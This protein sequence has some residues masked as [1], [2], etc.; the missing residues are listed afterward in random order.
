MP[1]SPN[2]SKRVCTVYTVLLGVFIGLVGRLAWIQLYDHPW[3]MEQARQRQF[4]KADILARR[5]VIFDRCKRVLAESVWVES[6]TADPTII[7]DKAG[8][9]RLLSQALRLDFRQTLTKLGRPKRFVWIKRFLS[10]REAAIVRQANLKGIFLVREAKRVYPLG[11]VACHLVGFCSIDGDGLEG[12]EAKCDAV[13]SGVDGHRD[14]WRDGAQRRL[15]LPSMSVAR[16]R[17]GRSVVLTVDS[18]IQAIVHQELA[19]AFAKL[20]PEAA[21]GIVLDCNTGGVLSM[22]SLPD[23]YPDRFASGPGIEPRRFT[24]DYAH[25]R[26]NRALTDLF[27]PGSIFK[28]FVASGAFELG[29][30][31][32]DDVFDCHQGSYAFGRRVL[33]DAHGYGLLTAREVLIKSSNIGLAQIAQKAGKECVYAYLRKFGFGQTTGFDL[34]GEPCGVLRQPQY[35]KP[36]YSLPS[37]GMGQEVSATPLRLA[38]SFCAL[39]N[40]GVVPRPYVIAAHENPRTGEV[41]WRAQPGQGTVRAIEPGTSRGIMAPILADVVKVGTGRYAAQEGYTLAGKTGTAQLRASNGRGYAAKAFFSSF[42]ALAPIEAPKI[43]VAVMMVRPRVDGR[44]TYY[45]GTAS[46][47]VAGR[48][49]KQTLHYLGV[50]PYESYAPEIP[51]KKACGGSRAAPCS[52]PN[53]ARQHID[54]AAAG[55]VP[56]GKRSTWPGRTNLV[57]HY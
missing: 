37:I 11:R 50:R 4:G 22:V 44:K 35:W 10:G 40:G 42:I 31:K 6:A 32:P 23:Y 48:I 45:G 1:I 13:L 8:V 21:M 25:L 26:R 38:V 39:G 49:A 24:R 55:T 19:V 54:S 41:D 33:H 46:A 34:P 27:E 18:V 53:P 3:F 20:G 7:G 57:K 43:C 16:P 36:C 5:G 51:V 12:V 9:A 28:P 47:P 52:G 56:I 2:Q 17:H 14:V 29:T 15:A 30:V